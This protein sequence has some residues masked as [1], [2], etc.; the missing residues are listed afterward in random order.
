M[1]E[2]LDACKGQ[3]KT[4]QGFDTSACVAEVGDGGHGRHAPRQTRRVG[5]A[6]HCRL[7]AI[8]TPEKFVHL[9]TRKKW[10]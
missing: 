2:W 1:G 3:G 9:E 7:R 8:R 5:P 6:R 4:F 10:L